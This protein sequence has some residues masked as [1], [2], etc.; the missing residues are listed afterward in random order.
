MNKALKYSAST[1]QED[2]TRPNKKT[3]TCQTHLK[4]TYGVTHRYAEA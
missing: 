3:A 1:R 4:P 2:L